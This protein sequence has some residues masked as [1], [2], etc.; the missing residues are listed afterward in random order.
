M[1]KTGKEKIFCANCANCK[2]VVDNRGDHK[3][4]RVRCTAGKWRKQQGGE[5]IYKYFTV[6]RRER[7]YCEAYLPM[8]D[9]EEF[10]RDLKHS[11]PGQDEQYDPESF[12]VF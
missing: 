1:S 7:E 9:P 3:R 4:L 10:I 8:G 6:S 5:K 2:L 11:L 12:E